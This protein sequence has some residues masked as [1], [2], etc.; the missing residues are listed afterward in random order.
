MGYGGYHPYPR[1]FGGGKPH[2]QVIHESINAQCGT[3]LDATNENTYVWLEN[4]A[5]AR[6]LTFDG[7]GSNQRLAYQWDP[8]KV[9]DMMPRWERIFAIVPPADMPDRQRRAAL[10]ARWER[11]GARANHTRMHDL[12]L[13]GLGD[14]FF[15][16]EYISLANANVHVPDGSY[17]W[18]TVVA[19]IPWYSTVSH[20]LIRLQKPAFATEADF[21]NAAAKVAPILD[22][23]LAG[24]VTWDWYRAPADPYAAIDVA[25]GPSAGG[26]YLDS[27]HTL[28]NHVFDV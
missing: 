2:L 24:W 20:I 28:D 10:T 11:F 23:L 13:A 7:W 25:G 26:I 12:L 6:A 15:A 14:Y 22:P 5:I 19:G 17:P 27:D 18:G 1:R 3:A 8:R 9:T 4:M 16:V 21:Y